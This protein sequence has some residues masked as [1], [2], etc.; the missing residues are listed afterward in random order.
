MSGQ[1]F[2]TFQ[3]KGFMFML[4]MGEKKG[5]G[6]VTPKDND[7]SGNARMMRIPARALCLSF[8]R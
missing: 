3:G 6:G 5:N 1:C 7:N 4:M 8:L 2:Q